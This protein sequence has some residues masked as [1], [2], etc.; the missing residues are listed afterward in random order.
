M[1]GDRPHRRERC[2]NR[3]AA[4]PVQPIRVPMALGAV[5][6]GVDQGAEVLDEAL[7]ARFVERQERALADRLRPSHT[8]P[9]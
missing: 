6:R 2:D 5:R 9:V 7:R 8:V 4:G 1:E 3:L